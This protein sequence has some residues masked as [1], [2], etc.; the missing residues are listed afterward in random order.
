M[1]SSPTKTTL[2]LS[3]GWA[4]LGQRLG[5]NGDGHHGAGDPLKSRVAMEGNGQAK[6]VEAKCGI[7]LSQNRAMSAASSALKQL[8]W[9]QNQGPLPPRI[10]QR[11]YHKPPLRGG[12]STPHTYSTR[13]C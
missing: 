13:W 12:Q 7:A 2:T 11:R 1:T 6:Q 9:S 5:C 10:T 3:A 8:K 4:L